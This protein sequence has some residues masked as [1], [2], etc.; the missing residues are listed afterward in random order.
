[1]A[2]ALV[3]QVPGE[4]GLALL[5]SVGAHGVNPKR[6]PSADVVEEVDGAVAGLENREDRKRPVKIG[7]SGWTRTTN[8]PVNRTPKKK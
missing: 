3:R 5:A 2:D 8:P 7:S 4:A 6:K 1:V